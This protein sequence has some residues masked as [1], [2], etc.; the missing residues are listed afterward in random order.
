MAGR[1]AVVFCAHHRPW[2]MMST[3]ITVVVQDYQDADFYVIYNVGDGQCPQKLSYQ[4]YH[5]IAERRAQEPRPDHAIEQKSEEAY[6]HLAREYGINP[7]LSPFD[8]RVRS[9][10]RIQR[11]NVFELEFENDHGLDS[12]AWYKFIRS[13]LWRK[14]EY[15]FFLQEGT[16]LTRPQVMS[17]ALRMAREGGVHFLAGANYKARLPKN[18]FLHFNGRCPNP[19]PIDEFHDRMIGETFEVF[20]RDPR[21]RTLFDAWTSGYAGDQQ[22]HVPDLGRWRRGLLLRLLQRAARPDGLP[23]PGRFRRRITAALTRHPRT[24]VLLASWMAQAAILHRE[25]FPRR[26]E[27]AN[28][29]EESMIHVNGVKRRVDDVVS[30]VRMNGVRFHREA[31]PEWHGCHCNHM[32]SR[33]FLDRLSDMLET[34]NMY[35]ALDLPFAGT[36]LEVIWG[37][38]PKC[39]G[40]E[41]WFFDGFHRVMKDFVTYRR[42]DDPAGMALHINQ[43]YLGE[44]YVEVEGD[45][46][47]V[48]RMSRS[49]QRPKRTLNDLY[50]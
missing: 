35:D 28:S 13:G 25:T 49:L 34:R 16:L 26:W 36:A 14:Y 18:L 37:F 3:L 2:L 15:V 42:E 41:K 7:K 9:V 38:L 5:R 12:G 19:L 31:D 39:L 21:F 10:C 43:Y 8:E 29:R 17:S 1:V 32:L 50:S 46:I 24:M 6:A 27:S 40:F 23:P 4:D 33:E 30:T 44:L 45:Y 22:N 11:A 20:C 47:K 48:R